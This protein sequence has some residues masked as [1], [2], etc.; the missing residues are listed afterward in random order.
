MIHDQRQ[1]INKTR[2]L[3]APRLLSFPALRTFMFDFLSKSTSVLPPTNPLPVLQSKDKPSPTVYGG[4]PRCMS[5][6]FLRLQTDSVGGLTHSGLKWCLLDG[7]GDTKVPDARSWELAGVQV[8]DVLHHFVKGVNVVSLDGQ[9]GLAGVELHL[10]G[11]TSEYDVSVLTQTKA[12]RFVVASPHLDSGSHLFGQLH[13]QTLLAGVQTV[14]D[15][16]VLQLPSADHQAGQVAPEELSH[17]GIATWVGGR[18]RRR[19][20]KIAKHT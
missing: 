19:T 15:I 4:A 12:A 11:E 13:V 1:L 17:P 6:F 3:A 9:R 2:Q 7:G 10:R 16:L 14:D 18:I 5:G 20:K 8:G